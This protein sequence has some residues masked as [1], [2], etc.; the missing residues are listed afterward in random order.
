M[1]DKS[2]IKKDLIKDIKTLSKNEHLQVFHIIKNA[3]V[4]YTENNNGIFINLNNINNVILNKL[5]KFVEYAKLNN[6]ELELSNNI[7]DK[8]REENIKIFY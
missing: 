7:I 6:N 5:I 1:I 2:N 4:K 3:G 8:I